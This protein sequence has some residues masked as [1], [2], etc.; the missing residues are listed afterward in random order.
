[1]S[2]RPRRA[3]ALVMLVATLACS[4]RKEPRPAAAALPP[5]V[6]A[7]V[8]GESIEGSS[9]ALI[10]ERQSLPPRAALARALSDAMFAAAGRA[11]LPGALVSSIERAAAARALLEQIGADSLRAGPPTDAETSELLRERWADLDRPEAVRVTHAVVI[12]GDPQR[13]AAARAVAEKLASAAKAAKSAQELKTLVES[14]PAEGFD[15]RAE[16]LPAITADGRSFAPAEKGFAAAPTTFDLDFARAAN[17][18]EQ[19]GELSP[20][21]RTR[22]GF[23]V[24]RLEERIPAGGVPKEELATLL[25]PE[26][27]ARRA[28]RL[29]A[30]LLE[31]LRGPSPVELDRAVDVLTAPI[32][33]GP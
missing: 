5:G 6:V 27:Q 9:V 1:M 13:E 29:R 10:A 7:R 8:E 12:N 2:R 14:V 33:T 23:H 11:T 17:Q 28:A 31:K 30:E 22:F 25:G 24:I 20:V 21:V 19:P 4:T 15:V 26:V 32:Q 18:L 16:E 3:Y